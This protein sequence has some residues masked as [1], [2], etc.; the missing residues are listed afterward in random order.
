MVGEHPRVVHLVDVITGQH[1]HVVGL[2]RA[3]DV[4]ALE[5]GVRRAAVPGVVVDPLLRR[6]QVDELVHLRL[7]EV[8]AALQM[9]QQ[10]VRLVLSEHADPPHPRVHAVGEHEIDDPELAAEMDGRLGAVVSQLLQATAA[11]PREHQGHTLIQ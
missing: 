8:P 10:A 2:I 9:P 3:D 7:Q 4:E 6:D 11:S 5:H 1:D